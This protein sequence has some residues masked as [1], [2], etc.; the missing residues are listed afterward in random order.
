MTLTQQ[1]EAAQQHNEKTITSRIAAPRLELDA[2]EQRHVK[3]FIQWAKDRGVK[4]LPAS[5]A[6]VA[7]YV[8]SEAESG[9][10][11]EQ[12]AQTIEAIAKLHDNYLLPNP[13]AVAV[14]RAE[15]SAAL[16]VSPPRNWKREEQ[17]LFV[18][19]PPDVQAIVARRAKTDSDLIRKLQNQ[20]AELKKQ[21]GSNSN[22]KGNT[23]VRQEKS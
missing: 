12:I 18:T 19:L 13:T 9:I 2:N 17:L 22:T 16:Q 3:L 7:S 10:G 8:R 4:S 20:N 6:V 1:I 15:L 5:P 21:L 11:G 23:D 14:V